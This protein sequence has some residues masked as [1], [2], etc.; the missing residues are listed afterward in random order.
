MNSFSS[1][2]RNQH[3]H[4]GLDPGKRE[5]K[6]RKKRRK[7]AT[8][9]SSSS[10]LILEEPATSLR[11]GPAQEGEEVQERVEEGGYVYRLQLSALPR[12][13][14]TLTTVWAGAGR[15]RSTGKRGRRPL[16]LPAVAR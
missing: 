1:S 7:A 10:Q 9:P 4:Y 14:S 3:P 15:R 12:G 11:S 2:T 6:R 13:T 5:E 16:C 8:S